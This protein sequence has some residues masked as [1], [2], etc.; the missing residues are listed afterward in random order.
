MISL[1]K[2]VDNLKGYSQ[3]IPLVLAV[4]IVFAILFVGI[5]V[6]SEISDSLLGTYPDSPTGVT[7]DIQNRSIQRMGN[8]S[9]NEDSALDIVQVVIIITILASAIAAIFMF[10]RFR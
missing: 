5:F 7:G 9:H 6:N 1:R 8:I 10:T 4:V 2:L 3:I